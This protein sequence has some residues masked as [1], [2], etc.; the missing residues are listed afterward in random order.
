MSERTARVERKTKETDI[1]VAV[2][3]DGTGSSSVQTGLNFLDHMLDALV[4][5]SRMD[6]ELTCK[7]DLH[8]DDHHT[9]ED[10][11][12]ALGEAIDKALGDKRGIYRFGS[13]YAPLDEALARA[14]IDL[15]GRPYAF[16]EIG[17][18]REKVGDT[19]SEMIG[20]A[21]SSFA[22]ATKMTLHVDLLRGDNDHHRAEAAFKAVALALRHAIARDGTSDVPSTKGVL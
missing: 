22:T 6:V 16:V 15:S 2:N 9:V 12:I 17:L 19:S 13:A 5:H 11:A 3:L 7:G 8:V 18:R 14:V 21:L 1:T 10:C 4:R 20:H